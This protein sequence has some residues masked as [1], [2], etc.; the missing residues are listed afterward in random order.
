MVPLSEVTMTV[1][2]KQDEQGVLWVLAPF[3]PLILILIGFNGLNV[4]SDSI[5]FAALLVL[6]YI[7]LPIVGTVVL[8][9]GR[10]GQGRSI[11][12]FVAFLDLLLFFPLSLYVLLF[13]VHLLGG[14]R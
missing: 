10:A 5:V 14:G 9:L 13:A 6:G 2:F 1:P 4:E 8:A 3:L 12:R 11:A 7:A